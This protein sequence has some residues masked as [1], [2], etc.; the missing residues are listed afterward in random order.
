MLHLNLLDTML[1]NDEMWI[2]YA[3]GS[4]VLVYDLPL[5]DV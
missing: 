3:D 1:D 5:W 2:V 4:A